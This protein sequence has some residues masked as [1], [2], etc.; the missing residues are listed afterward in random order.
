MKSTNPDTD[1]QD[2][3]QILSVAVDTISEL[4]GTAVG[5]GGTG[6]DENPVAALGLA[7]EQR[8]VGHADELLGVGWSARVQ[9]GHADRH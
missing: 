4:Y 7:V 6:I 2:P 3:D 1:M 5:L 8:L 9:R